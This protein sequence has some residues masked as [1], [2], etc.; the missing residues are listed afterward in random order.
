M[1]IHLQ[2]VL[3]SASASSLKPLLFFPFLFPL[4]S[5]DKQQTPVAS[6]SWAIAA[7]LMW[8][9]NKLVGFSRCNQKDVADLM[10]EDSQRLLAGWTTLLACF[11]F[12]EE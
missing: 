5:Q 9:L 7:L 6:I 3:K 10:E 1:L 2:W 12:K 4:K 11:N 8:T